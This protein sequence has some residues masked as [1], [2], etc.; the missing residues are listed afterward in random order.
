[1]KRILDKKCKAEQ[2]SAFAHLKKG[3]GVAMSNAIDGCKS[4][5]D[6]VCGACDEDS[7]AHWVD[8]YLL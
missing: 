5:A 2:N 4:V 7:V 6:N 1:M 3:V 8:E